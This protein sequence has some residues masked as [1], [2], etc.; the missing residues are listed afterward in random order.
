MEDKINE[1]TRRKLKH[2]KGNT[3]NEFSAF[4]DRIAKTTTTPTND[5]TTEMHND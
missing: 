4:E 2:H 3:G 5:N 1:K